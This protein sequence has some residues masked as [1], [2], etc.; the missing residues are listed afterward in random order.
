MLVAIAVGDEARWVTAGQWGQ[1]VSR[2]LKVLE[3]FHGEN[4]LRRGLARGELRNRLQRDYP[5][6]ALT[7]RLFN[8]IVEAA[9]T[10]NQIGADDGG[11]WRSGFEVRLSPEQEETV[12]R[13]LGALAAHGYSPP[14]EHAVVADLGQDQALLDLLLE[15]G[16]LV[17]VAPGIVYRREEYIAIEAAIRD[18]I[19]AHQSITLAEARDLLDT[20]RKYAQAVLENMDARRIT[21]REGDA[22]VLRVAQG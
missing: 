16:R 7:V 11:V 5:S 1:V 6:L 2:L 8:A 9:R 4:P 10:E 13:T 18:Y 14:A 15:D 20:S 21:R 19:Q 17:R 3:D 12:E 22:R